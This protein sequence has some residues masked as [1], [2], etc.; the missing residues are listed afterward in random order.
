M[1]YVQYLST[2][3]SSWHRVLSPS[4]T[5]S[6]PKLTGG[7]PEIKNLRHILYFV[8]VNCLSGGH[9]QSAAIL[10]AVT[11]KEMDGCAESI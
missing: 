1:T 11:E 8:S 7:Y 6:L 2:P 9:L 5:A 4:Q 3:G 10:H